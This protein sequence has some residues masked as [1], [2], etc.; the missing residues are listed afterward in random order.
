MN[1]LHNPWHSLASRL[2]V[3][4][5]FVALFFLVGCARTPVATASVRVAVLDGRV[6]YPVDP[7]GEVERLGWWFGSRDRYMASNVGIIAGDV[8]AREFAKI[9]GVEVYSRDDYVFYM[10]QKER[11]LRRK[12]PDLSSQA[13]K[14]ILAHMDPID[15][16]RSLNVDYVIQAEIRNAATTTNLTISAWWSEL[17]ASLHIY[18]VD[19]GHRIAVIPYDR[20]RNFHSQV[21]MLENFARRGVREVIRDDPFRV[22]AD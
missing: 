5:V 18:N 11:L 8:I 1:T 12:F 6:M 21:A 19:T 2:L 22:L 9:P 20:S 13:R 17:E 4:A 14:T 10:A 3:L 7:G 15:Y 16:G